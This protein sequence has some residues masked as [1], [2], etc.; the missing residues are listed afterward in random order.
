[1]ANFPSAA[2]TCNFSNFVVCFMNLQQFKPISVE[3]KKGYEKHQQTQHQMISRMAGRRTQRPRNRDFSGTVIKY[4]Y[5]GWRWAG[6]TKYESG[7]WT[8]FFAQNV[9]WVLPKMATGLALV[10]KSIQVVSC[11]SALP[12]LMLGRMCN[13]CSFVLGIYKLPWCPEKEVSGVEIRGVHCSAQKWNPRM[14]S[15]LAGPGLNAQQMGTR[16]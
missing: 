13:F 7:S 15:K 9:F 8:V 6:I 5:G 3:Q 4:F 12:S 14:W 16:H 10:S 1:M 11:I 2:G